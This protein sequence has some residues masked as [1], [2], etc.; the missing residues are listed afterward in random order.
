MSVGKLWKGFEEVIYQGNPPGCDLTKVVADMA[1]D[2]GGRRVEAL[3]N[4]LSRPGHPSEKATT[5]NPK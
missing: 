3:P 2:T 1:N 4:R 5:G